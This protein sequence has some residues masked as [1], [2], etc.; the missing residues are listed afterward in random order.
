M[1]LPT[2]QEDAADPHLADS[3][4]LR[5]LATRIE[6]VSAFV[7]EAAQLVVV[8]DVEWNDATA[9]MR[10]LATN[11]AL[12]RQLESLRAALLL[13]RQD[14]GDL[15]VALVRPALEDVLYLGVLASLSLEES[16]ELLTLLAAWDSTRCARTFGQP[17]SLP[18]LRPGP[19]RPFLI[20]LRIQSQAVNLE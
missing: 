3:P 5:D 9:D 7:E 1:Q 6:A 18:P 20:P 19:V 2:E 10:L 16:Q 11:L 17:A 4:I 15:A 13:A 12:L 8:G 14:L